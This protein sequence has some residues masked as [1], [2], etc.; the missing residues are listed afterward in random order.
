[1]TSDIPDSSD[2]MDG[3]TIERWIPPREMTIEVAAK[4]L[5]MTEHHV[6]KLLDTGLIEFRQDNGER[7]VQTESL[8]NFFA[9]RRQI[10]WDLYSL[11]AAKGSLRLPYIDELLYNFIDGRFFTKSGLK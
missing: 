10:N 9:E 11:A 3:L 2:E 5:E 4:I 7:F 1:M 6:N 8:V